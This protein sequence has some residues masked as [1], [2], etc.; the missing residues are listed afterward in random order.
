MDVLLAVIAA[1]F[2]LLMGFLVG[3][4]SSEHKNT[5][6]IAALKSELQRRDILVRDANTSAKFRIRTAESDTAQ[7]AKVVTARVRAYK[8]KT[9]EPRRGNGKS[10]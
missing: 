7:K 5:R 6:E 8:Y 2:A 9:P 4:G 3:W 10:S 1:L